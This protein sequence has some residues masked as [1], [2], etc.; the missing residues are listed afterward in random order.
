MTDFAKE[1][2]KVDEQLEKLKQSREELERSVRQALDDL[3]IIYRLLGMKGEKHEA[4]ATTE[5]AG[6]D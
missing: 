2:A 3:Q 4:G 1:L 6:G 5:N